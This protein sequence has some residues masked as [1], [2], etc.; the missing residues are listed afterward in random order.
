[1]DDTQPSRGLKALTL[2]EG[3]NLWLVRRNWESMASF[4]TSY[5]P[6]FSP[7]RRVPSPTL[8]CVKVLPS[9]LSPLLSYSFSLFI[10]LLILVISLYKGWGRGVLMLPL[11]CLSKQTPED[12]ETTSLSS[13]PSSI[14]SYSLCAGLGGLGFL[15]TTYL[16]YLKLTNSDAFCPVGGGTCSDVLNSDYATVFGIQLFFAHAYQ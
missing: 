1:M 14:S 11:S 5:H 12:S 13:S 8:P 3:E 4:V 16:T 9:K 6:L 2:A 7:S 15:E 10:G